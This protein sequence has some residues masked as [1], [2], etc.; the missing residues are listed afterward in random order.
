[1]EFK[2]QSIIKYT[3]SYEKFTSKIK[4]TVSFNYLL[5]LPEN[6]SPEEKLPMIVFLHGAGERGT[7]L[8][9]LKNQGI[10]RMLDSGLVVRAIV[11][12][13]QI[14]GERVWNTYTDELEELI[15]DTKQRCNADPNRI[16]LTGLSMGGFGTWELAISKTELFSAIAPICGGGM[17]WRAGKLKNMPVRAYC[18]DADDTVPYRNTVEMTDRINACGGNAECIIL[19]NVGHNSWDWAYEHSDLIQ[20]LVSNRRI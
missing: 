18:G 2:N 9:I 17:S 6:F 13:P 14:D 16:S 12:A 8:N 4:K 5:A 3:Q 7:E 10:P 20:W 19:H 15:S 11:L 1:M